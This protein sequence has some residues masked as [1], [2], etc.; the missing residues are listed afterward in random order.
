MSSKE[1]QKTTVEERTS[2]PATWKA[3]FPVP[4]QVR[5]G[6]GHWSWREIDFESKLH[7]FAGVWSNEAFVSSQVSEQLSWKSGKV[8]GCVVV[9]LGTQF[10]TVEQR[11]KE[12]TASV[13]NL[14]EGCY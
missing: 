5:E 7:D 3:S 10:L 14:E 1:V 2:K 13:G 6:H 12:C 8:L 11:Q 9:Q 4:V